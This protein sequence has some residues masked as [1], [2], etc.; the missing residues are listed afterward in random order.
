[1]KIHTHC[2]ENPIDADLDRVVWVAWNQRSRKM[3]NWHIW[4]DYS[5][6]AKGAGSDLRSSLFPSQGVTGLG[7]GDKP[8]NHRS[9][10]VQTFNHFGR[11]GTSTSQIAALE[12]R[13]LR[14]VKSTVPFCA[15]A[16]DVPVVIRR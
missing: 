14:L 12:F 9:V 5:W 11:T 13:E 4:R 1:M 6:K 7:A 15:E 3:A 16:D 8:P 10:T 2:S